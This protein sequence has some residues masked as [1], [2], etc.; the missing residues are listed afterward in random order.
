MRKN[1]NMRKLAN[2]VLLTLLL[3]TAA[4]AENTPAKNTQKQ[5]TQTQKEHPATPKL[6]TLPGQEVWKD[7]ASSFLFGTNDTYE[8]SQ[9]N[10]QTES[11][12]QDALRLAGVTLIRSFF[13][14]NASD[15]DIEKRMH[16]IENSGAKCLGVITNIS[17]T[18]FN[19]HLVKYLGKRCQMYEFGNESDYNN[20]TLDSYLKQWNSDIPLL[21]KDNPD[22]I[23][24]GPV[25]YNNEGNH[26]FMQGFLEGVK[27]SQVLPDA[28]SFHWY[29]CY[30]DSRESCLQKAHS[31]SQVAQGVHTLIR[32]TLGK[33]L[34]VGITEWNYDPGNPPPPYGDDKDFI[35]Q[36]SR[37]ALDS[38]VQGDV[39]F[40][41]Q[42]DAASYSGYGRLDMFDVDT[43]QPKP[44]YYALKDAIAKYRPVSAQMTPTPPSTS[45]PTPGSGSA[46]QSQIQGSNSAIVSRGKPVVCTGN[47]DGAGGPEA[48]VDGKYGNWGFWRNSLSTL[49]S[50]CAIQVGKGPTSL[51]LAWQSDY[52]F[53]YITDEG[54]SPQDYTISTSGDSTDGTNGNWQTVATVTD[55][56]TRVREHLVP[57]KDQ[58]WV[59]MTVTKGQ[60]KASQPYVTIDEIDLY[61]VSSSRNDTFFFCGDSIT[62]IAYSRADDAQPSFQ[63]DVHKAYP[64]HYPAMIDGGLGGWNSDGAVQN[65][66]SWLQLNPDI[67]YWLLGWGTNDAMQQVD[68]QHY[69]ANMQTLIDKLKQAGRV[70]VIARI[71]AV[72]LPGDRGTTVNKEIQALNDTINEL[73]SAN[74]LIAGPDFYSMFSAQTSY[75]QQDG[76][77]PS[78]SASVAMNQAWFQA[79]EQP[80]YKQGQ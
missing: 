4:C 22:A 16:T 80:V 7:N 34:P 3:L 51:L 61:D 39:A 33:D 67:H 27:S 48:I 60:P 23:F 32:T 41:C 12:I 53:D 10:I 50:S 56:H 71:P 26:N 49:P 6:T 68:P 8:W 25:T 74:G 72:N 28:V 63:E 2:I 18:T 5:T 43:N 1:V 45:T 20:I 62:A 15:E 58:V 38:M 36:Y 17:N 55:N 9:K 73:T 64:Q 35:T 65:I 37:D 13:P 11:S 70:P 77:H 40:A 54:M 57:F 19:E 14:D 29:P 66:D 52:V 75:F 59:K 21:R 47:A 30:E 31:Y 44:Q 42:F 79:L 46:P 24:I 78:P 76:I 69:K